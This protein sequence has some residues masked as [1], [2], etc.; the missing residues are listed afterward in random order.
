MKFEPL[1]SIIGYRNIFFYRRLADEIAQLREYGS[2]HLY[3]TLHLLDKT[4]V[5]CEKGEKWGKKRGKKI[6]KG[7]N[8]GC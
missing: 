2:L 4:D 5:G 8:T 6:K 1:F 3:V 7:G